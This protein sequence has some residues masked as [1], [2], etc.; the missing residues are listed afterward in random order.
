MRQ[1]PLWAVLLCGVLACTA[2][3]ADELPL[4]PARSV[5]FDTDAV[6]WLSLD[7]APDGATF[8]IEVLGDLYTLPSGGG[9]ATAITN[10]MAFDSQPAFS[11]D[12][13]SIAFVSDR[14]GEENIWIVD[15]DGANPRKISSSGERTEFASPNWASDGTHVIA[16]KTS[17][18]L[19]TFEVWAYHLDGGKGVRL[20]K[21][22]AKSSTPISSRRNALG[23][24]YG[25]DGR[26][27]Y[28]SGKSGGFGYN[29]GLPQ[30]QIVRR[31]L[32]N[33][34]ED[35]LTNAQG[36][37]FRPRLS[38]DGSLL[39]YATRYETQT[40]LRIRDLDSGVDRWLA[41]PVQRD[42]QES[43]FTRD[44]FP[45]YAFAPDGGKVY[46][47]RNGGIR[48]VDVDTGV[49]STIPFT[50]TVDQQLGPNLRFPYRIGLGPVKAR[51]AR[52]AKLSPDESKIVFSALT[53]VYVMDI[54][55]Q[56]ITPISPEGVR[57]TQP[58]WSPRGHELVYVSWSPRGG[59]IWRARASGRGRPRQ[60]T[61]DPAFYTD[62]V[63]APD[64][65]SVVALRATSHERLARE[66]DSGSPVGTDLIRLP[67]SGGAAQV[68]RPSRGLALPH[69][70]PE[71]DRVYLSSSAGLVSVNLEGE[72]RRT[73][74]TA[75]GTA[76]YNSDDNVASQAIRI[77]PDGLNALVLHADQL[78][79]A[80]LLGTKKQSIEVNLG[81]SSLPLEQLTNVGADDFGWSRDGA[82]VH[83]TV[84]HEFNVRPLDSVQFDG[85]DDDPSEEDEPPTQ[86]DEENDET[87]ATARESEP[88]ATVETTSQTEQAESKAAELPEDHEA[89]VKTDLE[90]YL[91]R[92]VPEGRV[93]LVGGTVITMARDTPEII[94]DAVVLVEDGRISAIGAHADVDVPAQTHR[95]D[96]SG[97]YVL[98]GFI[99]THAHYR[100]LRRVLDLTNWA[101]LANLAYGVTTGLDVQPGT[102]DVLDY[103][104]LVDA[105]LAIGPRTL[106]TGPG[107][108]S[109]NAF[110]SKD[111]ALAVLR[112]YKYHYGVRNLKAYIA[113]SRKQRQWL[114]Q[115]ANELRLMPTT[116]GAL[117]MKL[118]L[119]HAIDG[120]SGNEHNLPVLDLHRDVVELVARSGMSYT[121][122][123]IVAY[124]GPH[125]E[126]YFYTRES[127]RHD[128]KLAR[129]TP[130]P[131]LA[132][133]TLR[134][135]WFHDDVHAFS[136][137]AE[138]AAKIVRA[139]GRVGVGA[140]GQLQGLGFHWE[141][142]AL[143]SGGFTPFEV[144]R[145][146]TRHGAE[147][148]GVAQDIGSI[149]AGKLA[150]LVVVRRN[151]L[152]DIRATAEL[153]YVVKNGVV[154]DAATLDE[155]WPTATP[156][157][158]H[159]WREQGPAG[160]DE[161]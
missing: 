156:M 24:V 134:Q 153:S 47:T 127:P 15:V 58:D 76:T 99:D 138:Q 135:P 117:D 113:G 21:A 1:D 70:G 108:F 158:R 142:W 56:K 131:V 132:S 13:S 60:L 80:R 59:H 157:P 84:G 83:W 107:V 22:K 29:V 34:Q 46:F 98:P 143:A 133:R 137:V 124:G 45:G 128:D 160:V 90:I 114:V 149:E 14:D 62:P 27:L 146:A 3:A 130:A 97:Q 61:A 30:W 4:Q 121:P 32:S 79:V 81:S 35:Y 2:F 106:S 120:F 110:K 73:H 154:H 118:D 26:Y 44:L 66:Y 67:S 9:V 145:A 85:D 23:A 89:V 11:P 93:A 48:A 159:W 8:V 28:Y 39:V 95:I 64:G 20:T 37:A 33:G 141:M 54:G 112:R 57:A 140:H 87:A 148:V 109:N 150:D 10:G 5:T 41:F 119:T 63:W 18:G 139:G 75:K 82:K 92:A 100:V 116:E 40:G 16:S 105:G 69:F 19:R 91:P 122:T 36:S 42:E 74:L 17:W 88:A 161:P 7:V 123:L 86:D 68:I 43:R 51:L 53:R 77:S 38:P 104:D 6:T 111:H 78:Y 147:I 96:V 55:T 94:A 49:V 136:R 25:P 144:L 103:E 52:F 31:D 65:K 50:L 125:G 151:P 71:P 152:E 12:G 101:L 126:S 155:V 115:A 129:F 72:D 102:V